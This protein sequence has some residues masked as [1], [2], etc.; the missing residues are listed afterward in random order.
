MSSEE[1]ERSVSGLRRL[2]V[3]SSVLLPNRSNVTVSVRNCNVHF[4]RTTQHSRVTVRGWQHMADD[5]AVAIRWTDY[6]SEPSQGVFPRFLQDSQWEAA[7]TIWETLTHSLEQT[8]LRQA[9]RAAQE[10]QIPASG[11]LHVHVSMEESS[12]YWT[13]AV[14]FLLAPEFEF[15]YL[16][17]LFEPGDRMMNVNADVPIF[18]GTAVNVCSAESHHAAGRSPRTDKPGERRRSSRQLRRRRR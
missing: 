18:A 5:D 4:S 10:S 9:R 15:D 14:Q 8:F 12:P 3:N 1:S 13:C 16:D 17:I 6:Q 11:E 7:P 2:T